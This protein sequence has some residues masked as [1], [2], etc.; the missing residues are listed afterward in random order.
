MTISAVALCPAAVS[1]AAGTGSPADPVGER[2][3]RRLEATLKPP[4]RLGIAGSVATP[5][6]GGRGAQTRLPPNPYR[7]LGEGGRYRP[8]P[9]RHCATGDRIAQTQDVAAPQDEP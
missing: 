9:E 6:V 5:R 7:A 1:N 3:L 2:V 4:S 8:R